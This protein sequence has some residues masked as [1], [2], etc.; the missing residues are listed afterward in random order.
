V[1]TEAS[2]GADPTIVIS[3]DIADRSRET[4]WTNSGTRCLVETSWVEGEAAQQLA[5]QLFD[6][7]SRREPGFDLLEVRVREND[8]G[9]RRCQLEVRRSTGGTGDY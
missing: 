8:I 3:R 2:L 9:S 1:K 5:V 6:G 7:R 4:S